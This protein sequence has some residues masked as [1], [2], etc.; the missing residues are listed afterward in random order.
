MSYGLKS[1]V[2]FP[3]AKNVTLNAFREHIIQSRVRETDILE[4]MSFFERTL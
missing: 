1:S 3:N 4:V 2:R